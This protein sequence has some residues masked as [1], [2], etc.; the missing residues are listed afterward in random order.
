[1][2]NHGA[3]QK[4]QRAHRCHYDDDEHGPGEEGRRKAR[5]LILTLFH[6]QSEECHER[7]ASQHSPGGNE[8]AQTSIQD[9]V[10]LAILFA[11]HMQNEASARDENEIENGLS[12]QEVLMQGLLHRG[13]DHL[14]V[15][16]RA[17]KTNGTIG[18]TRT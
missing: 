7:L 9:D 15:L 11:R 6:C 16:K 13:L 4:V 8:R 17:K 12:S 5:E 18:E 14:G 3:L 1:M 2:V 10:S